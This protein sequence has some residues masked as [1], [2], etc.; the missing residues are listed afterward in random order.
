MFWWH[1]TVTGR[2]RN[3]E[4]EIQAFHARAIEY[5]HKLY[6]RTRP[7]KH[8]VCI[9]GVLLMRANSAFCIFKIP[10][11]NTPGEDLKFSAPLRCEIGQRTDT[12]TG[13]VINACSTH[14]GIPLTEP[15]EV[16]D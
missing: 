16:R 15:G 3:F 8:E 10:A 2:K 6:R 11:E 9:R 13:G 4:S 12:F 1:T 14:V 5:V 7:L